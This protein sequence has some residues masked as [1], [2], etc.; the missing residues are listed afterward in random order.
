MGV[1]LMKDRKVRHF[2]ADYCNNDT[3]VEGIFPHH[4]LDERSIAHRLQIATTKTS[5]AAVVATLRDATPNPSETTRRH[6]EWLE[7]GNTVAVVAGQQ[8]GLFLGPAFAFYKAAGVIRTA[9]QI[10]KQ[11]GVRAVPIFWLQNEDHDIE[12]IR[13]ATIPSRDGLVVTSLSASTHRPKTSIRDELLG[14]EITSALGTVAEALAGRAK[15][16]EVM[17][18]LG[19]HYRP[20]A[21]YSEA[22][23]GALGEWFADEGLL[24]V[25]ARHPQF[26]AASRDL[27]KQALVQTETIS[28]ALAEQNERLMSLGYSPTVYVRPRSPLLFVHPDGANGP[29]YRLEANDNAT[30]TVVGYPE[31][32]TMATGQLEALIDADPRAVSTSALLRPVIQDSLLPTAVMLGGPSELAYLAQCVPL[33][34][35]F[36][37]TLPVICPRPSFC[38]LLPRTWSLMRRIGL[39]SIDLSLPWDQLVARH[40]A[41]TEGGIPTPDVVSELLTTSLGDVIQQLH[42]ASVPMGSMMESALRKTENTLNFAVRRFGEHYRK[43][44]FIRDK[45]S[46]ERWAKLKAEIRPGNI[47]QERVVSVVA[48]AAAVGMNTFKHKVLEHTVP[49]TYGTKE[50]LWQT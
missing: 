2:A 7:Q 24:F 26:A 46:A 23:A 30:Y 6:L 32:R 29:R 17:D 9:Q 5:C 3:R 16:A 47:P 43:T 45:E 41:Q 8:V 35:L 4:F 20:D 28:A 14:P 10:H 18:W 50:I 11:F 34:S 37:Q 39:D 21:T 1:F 27:M 33:Y 31:H 36:R 42:L 22:F 40:L 48:Y 19:R 13:S 12:E 49:F 38:I 15:A 25:D 44:Y